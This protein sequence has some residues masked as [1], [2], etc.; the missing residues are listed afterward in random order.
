MNLTR[1]P[2]SLTA[3]AGVS[4]LGS[5]ALAD[6]PPAMGHL[7]KD[8][9][10]A[11]SVSN[12]NTVVDGIERITSAFGGMPQGGPLEALGAIRDLSGLDANGSAA[13]AFVFPPDFDPTMG[14]P[15]SV[16]IIPVTN[17][18]ELAEG[19]GGGA[20]GVSEIFLQGQPM[21]MKSL[22]RGYAVACSTMERAEGFESGGSA[23]AFESLMGRAGADL[24]PR[25]SPCST[26]SRWRR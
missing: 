24:A 4:L 25:S 14:E 3:F 12:I 5:S 23:D 13:A 17:Y 26:W 8:A 11:F 19:L 1:M 20:S 18:A 7:P 6:L 10:M 9:A 21:Y 15:D 2:L 22:G 16:L